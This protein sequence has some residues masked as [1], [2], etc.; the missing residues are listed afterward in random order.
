MMGQKIDDGMFG[1]LFSQIHFAYIFVACVLFIG[2]IYIAPTIV[3]RDIRWLLVYPRWVAAIMEK[4]FSAQ[5]G[6]FPMFFLILFLNNLSLFTGFVSG[7]L[8]ILPFLIA[9]FTGLHVAVIGYDLMGWQGLWHML[10]NPVAW[11]EF[12]A[13]WISFAL[14]FRLAGAMVDYR[15]FAMTGKVFNMLLPLYLKYAFVLLVIAALLE[16]LLIVIAKKYKNNL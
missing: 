8:I 15:N 7:Y 6:F 3:E 10:M 16:S 13:S 5:W 12:P 14:G 2:G 11:L 1:D 9:F 4:Y